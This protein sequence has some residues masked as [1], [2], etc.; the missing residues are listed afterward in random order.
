MLVPGQKIGVAVSGGADS[1]SLLF[2]LREL[3][4]NYGVCLSVLHLDHGL[5]GQESEADAEFVSKLAANLGLAVILERVTLSTAGENLEQAAR[6]ARLEFFRRQIASGAVNRVALGHTRSDQAETVL[7]RFLRGAATAGLAGIRPITS[8]GIVRPLIA[9]DRGHVYAFLN[10]RGIRWREDSSNQSLDFARNRIRHELLPQLA[11]EWN[12]AISRTLAQIAEWA[13]AEEEWWE[14]ETDRL[15]ASLLSGQG[16]RVLIRAADLTALPLASARRLVR[17]AMEQV[18]GDL[19]AIDFEHVSAVLDLAHRRAGHGRVCVPALEIVRSF[20]WVAFSVPEARIRYAI[21]APAPGAVE[22][23]DTGNV[24]CLELIER[25]ETQAASPSVYNSG[26]GCVDWPR[27]LGPLELRSWRPGDRYQP[28][29]HTGEEK[30]KSLF[31]KARVPLWERNGWP[32]LADRS[33]V[34]WSRR[35]GPQAALCA[36]AG[37][38]TVLCIREIVKLESKTP[39]RTS[40]KLG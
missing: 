20:D 33:G 19:R 24:I 17:R 30:I 11:R 40:I 29:G 37:A 4:P 5:R 38:K 10:G 14:S 3:A 16:S 9:V 26:M 18:K 15:A 28:I 23:P 34:I 39:S 31:Q 7:F 22:I 27:V 13:L 12:P 6:Q 1:V 2:A 32:V 36:D 21:E 8:D 25:Q 35:F